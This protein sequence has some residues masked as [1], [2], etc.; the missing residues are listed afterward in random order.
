VEVR[1][2]IA[3]ATSWM[4]GPTNIDDYHDVEW[5]V[6]GCLI[7]ASFVFVLAIGALLCRKITKPPAIMKLC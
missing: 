6:V 7:A 2:K 3:T 1:A 4:F 5:Y